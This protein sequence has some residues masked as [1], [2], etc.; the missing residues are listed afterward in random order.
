MKSRS[1]TTRIT[2]DL[3]NCCRRSLEEEERESAEDGE[4]AV[5]TY[6]YGADTHRLIRIEGKWRMLAMLLLVLLA[7]CGPEWDI[8]AQTAAATPTAVVQ[9][10]EPGEPGHRVTT[11]TYTV[12]CGPDC[13]AVIVW[14]QDRAENPDWATPPPTPRHPWLDNRT[15]W[16]TWT[17]AC[18]GGE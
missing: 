14:T 3:L 4:R 1:K 5:C 13:T 10:A 12:A 18:G 8:S 15:P 9:P 7:G 6:S 11:H 16:P 17:P 2:R